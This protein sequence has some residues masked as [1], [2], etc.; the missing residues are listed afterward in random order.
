MLTGSVEVDSQNVLLNDAGALLVCLF[1]IILQP[2]LKAQKQRKKKKFVF[3]VIHPFIV[4]HHELP[5]A[6]SQ[7]VDPF[8]TT[9]STAFKNLMCL[10]L[11][12]AFNDIPF[13]S[14]ENLLH[15]FPVQMDSKFVPNIDLRSETATTSQASAEK[16]FGN[17][18]DDVTGFCFGVDVD[19]LESIGKEIYENL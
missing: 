12:R 16:P 15:P 1:D 7:T 3:K 17:P 5:L 9:I 13:K 19:I 10:F 2:I 11:Y 8:C 6:A 14:D 4:D 18:L